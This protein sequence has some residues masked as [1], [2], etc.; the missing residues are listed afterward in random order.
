MSVPG[1]IQ[2]TRVMDKTR[3]EIYGTELKVKP[4]TRII[5]EGQVK[6]FGLVNRMNENRW[7]G[8]IRQDQ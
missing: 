5:E 2:G 4:V 8:E 7:K 3:N 1:K 6:W